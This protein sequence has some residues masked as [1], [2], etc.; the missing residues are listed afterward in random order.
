MNAFKC[1]LE[2]YLHPADRNPDFVEKLDFKVIKFPVKIRDVHKIE[3]K[4]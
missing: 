1:C 3:K 2:R 4:K